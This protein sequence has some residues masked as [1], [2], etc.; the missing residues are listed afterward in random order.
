VYD[1]QGKL[2]GQEEKD[3][4]PNKWFLGHDIDA[5]WDHRVLGIW[6]ANEKDQ[7]AKYGVFPGDFKI[8]DVDGD[9]KFSDADRQFLGFSTPRFQWTLRNEFSYKGFDLS[10]MLYSNWGQLASYNQAKNNSG[11]QDRQNS[12][13]FPYWTP[14]KPINDYARLYSS[15][16]GASFS[17]YRK[18]SF[19]RLNNIALAYTFPKSIISR[20]KIESA[21]IYV[22]VT[23]VGYYAPE[24]DFWDPEFRNRDDD[25]NISTAIPPRYYSL[26]LNV[27][28]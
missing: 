4:P 10:F 25:G 14:D 21:K 11:F 1:D 24:W 5:V 15:N 18:A 12:Y 26:G 20:A 9:F 22:N 7:A 19:I 16:G 3:D 8:D 2:I 17:V 27:T 6:Q 23:N 28:F 13:I